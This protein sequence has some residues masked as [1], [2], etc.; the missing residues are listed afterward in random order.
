[1]YRY[2]IRL[3]FV[4][5]NYHGWQVQNNAFTVQQQLTEA[6]GIITGSDIQLTGCGRTDA[7]VHAKDFYAHFD[8][9]RCFSRDEREK[10]LFRLNSFLPYDMVIK[11]IYP[12]RPD[13]HARFSA[14][15]RT[16]EYKICRIK[17]PFSYGFAYNLNVH[18]DV[19]IMNKGAELLMTCKD[20]SSF[21][22]TNSQVKTNICNLQFARWDGNEE[23]LTFTV[24]ANR[25]LRNM[26]RAMV[27]TLLDLGK[28]TI[29]IAML[30]DIVA[31]RSRSSAGYSVPAC[32][33]FLTEVIYPS[34]IFPGADNED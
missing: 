26:V 4:G 3:A 12:V 28:G 19:D 13:A 6:I 2:F 30:Q 17:N 22:K 9:N 5:S 25:F 20:F 15:F 8:Y 34:E 27:G 1:M 11:D 14:I 23:L 31:T 16:Y 21:A 7:G 33:L 18:L 32:G 10:L 29:D 24:T